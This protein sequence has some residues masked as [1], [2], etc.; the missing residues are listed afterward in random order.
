MI[1][2]THSHIYLPE[3]DGD[4]DP[5]IARAENEGI[6]LILMPAVDQETYAIMFKTEENYPGKCLSMIGLHPCSVKEGYKKD[7]KIVEAYLEKR[8]F[9]AIGETGLD[10]YWD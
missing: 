1:I 7:L 4:R 6:S 2:D 8:Q 10:F 9:V 3:F 5:M